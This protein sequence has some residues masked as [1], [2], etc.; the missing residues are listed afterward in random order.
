MVSSLIAFSI[1]GLPAAM[2]PSEIITAT[3]TTVTIIGTAII[4]GQQISEEF[5]EY[6][7]KFNEIPLSINAYSINYHFTIASSILF[8]SISMGLPGQSQQTREISIID[9]LS[10]SAINIFIMIAF[11][12]LFIIL[13]Y[14][15][16]TRREIIFF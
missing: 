3:T 5:I 8:Y 10:N 4:I 1:F 9:A 6:S 11:T 13:S 14:I 15:S 7:R 16:F 2:R 12:I